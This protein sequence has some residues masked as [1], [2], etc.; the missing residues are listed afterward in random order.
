[1]QA[2]CFN[3]I[4]NLRGV[5][6]M[7]ETTQANFRMP[8]KL[9]DIIEQSAK[10]NGRSITQEFVTA[11]ENTYVPKEKPKRNII[12]TEWNPTHLEL[13]DSD[14]FISHNEKV[15]LACSK[16][17]SE[18]LQRHPDYVLISFDFKSRIQLINKKDQDVLFGIRIWYSYPA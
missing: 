8:K 3:N 13:E 14:S 16:Y 7:S 12:F 5:I 2:L 4:T 6:R 10:D 15:R 9:K 11:L 18:F 1:M 17:M